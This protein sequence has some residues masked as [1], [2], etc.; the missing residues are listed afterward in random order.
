MS[1]LQQQAT[2]TLCLLEKEFSP[3]LFIIMT[4]LM[5]HL[6]AKVKLCGPIHT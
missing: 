4:H 2:I 5:V 1:D 3:S 6:V